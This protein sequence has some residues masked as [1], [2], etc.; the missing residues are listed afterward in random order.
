[1]QTFTMLG[2]LPGA[3]KSTHIQTMLRAGTYFVISPDDIRAMSIG[4][5]YGEYEFNAAN[6]ELTWEIAE[7]MFVSAAS[8][9]KSIILDGTFMGQRTRTSW[10]KLA[11]K[12]D[13][14]ST[15]NYIDTPIETCIA[16]RKRDN[17]NSPKTDWES[18]IK[19]M[20][21]SYEDAN[22]DVIKFDKVIVKE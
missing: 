21:S 13:M 10:V 11:I 18:I 6:E 19:R 17:K 7:D 9:G 12:F 1:M 3:G 2:G 15:Y 8:A 4:G 16:R 22:L 14:Y 5:N 20:A